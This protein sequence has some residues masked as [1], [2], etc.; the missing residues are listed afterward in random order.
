MKIDTTMPHA[1]DLF[2]RVNGVAQKHVI[3]IDTEQKLLTYRT[4][5]G[6]ETVEQD[7]TLHARTEE[8]AEYFAKLGAPVTC[9]PVAI[10]LTKI[11]RDRFDVK[12][13]GLRYL[14]NPLK[15]T[16]TW[17]EDELH[18]RSLV[19]D[20]TGVV[21]SAGFPKFV[22]Y[23]ENAAHDAAFRTALAR[24]EVE[25][26]EKLDGSL[27]IMDRRGDAV[28][29]ARTRGQTDLG[30][31][32]PP[33]EKLLNTKYPKL[34]LALLSR[35]LREL[36]ETHSILFEYIGPEN[37][38][39]VPYAE[40]GLVLLGVM[41]KSTLKP[42][43]GPEL[44]TIS[45]LT[46][47]PIAETHDLPTTLPELMQTVKGWQDKEGVVARFMD[48]D[49]PRLL[50]IKASQYV[51]LHALK[52]K[53]S[54]NVGKLLFL[55]GATTV[56]DARERLFNLGVDYEAQQFVEAEILSYI[57]KYHELTTEYEEFNRRLRAVFMA[58]DFDGTRK[59]VALTAREIVETE[60]YPAVFFHAAMK[61]YEGSPSYAWD[62]VCGAE[63]L[64]EPHSVVAKWKT[65]PMV[66][67]NDVLNVKVPDA[68]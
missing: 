40:S 3:E 37:R 8:A 5:E 30:D 58:P 56:A 68:D 42:S 27:L 38:I 23:G 13:R 11:D 15:S 4:P 67:I 48:G 66:S 60:G 21:L 24:G 64:Q 53:L 16:H 34:V 54:G 14:I 50:K 31:F 6:T 47:V 36:T 29:E 12:E 22:N 10:D 7:F 18:L 33:V 32:L 45:H 20:W 1:M 51:R 44:Q 57:E 65:N 43:W 49:T 28:V 46:G 9:V 35:Q 26:A 39:V 19:V 55:L 61:I 52:F 17:E 25:F 59:T 41:N 62:A 2:V 63:L